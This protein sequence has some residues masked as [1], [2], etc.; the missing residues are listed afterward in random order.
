M[1]GASRESMANL[2]NALE[3]RRSDPGISGLA[4]E[5]YQV[6]D[7]LGREKSLR[8]ALADSGQSEASRRALAEQLLGGRVRLPSRSQLTRWVDVGPKTLT[9][10]SHLSRWP[11]KRR[12][13]RRKTTAASTEPRRRSSDS[14]ALLMPR[15]SYRWP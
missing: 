3:A 11:H 12:L 4:A 10:Y 7:L 14:V 13:S 2:I 9:S 15:P 8:S 6:A 5:L 1:L